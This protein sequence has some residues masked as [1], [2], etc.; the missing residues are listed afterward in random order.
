MNLTLAGKDQED[1]GY[2]DKVEYVSI[3]CNS[4][5]VGFAERI[6]EKRCLSCLDVFAKYPPLAQFHGLSFETRCENENAN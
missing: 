6:V 1:P 2:L 5:S 3:G 4:A